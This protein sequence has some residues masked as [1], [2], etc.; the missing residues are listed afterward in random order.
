MAFQYIKG[1]YKKHGERLYTKA[2]RDRTRGNRSKLKEGKE[3][4][5]RLCITKKFF[6]I[7]MIRHCCPGMVCM[8]LI[9]IVQSWVG[10]DFQ[11]PD[12]VRDDPAH[13][14]GVGL[15]DGIVFK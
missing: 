2:C 5:F 4:S 12:L 14:K 6:T 8:P 13:G 7:R 15:D 9:G 10:W 11:Q 1:A 3:S